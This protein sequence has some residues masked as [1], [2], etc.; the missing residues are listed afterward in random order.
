LKRLIFALATAL[1][2]HA[3]QTFFPQVADGGP[4]SQK[5]T[6]S[7]TFI[8][9]SSSLS[10]PVTVSFFGNDGSPLALDFGQGPVSS[11]VIALPPV[12]AVTIKS[13]GASSTTV[14]G[15]AV[16]QF[17]YTTTIAQAMF[18]FT[19]NGVPQQG[20]TVPMTA[21]SDVFFSP[22]TF[23]TGVAVANPNSFA[24]QVNAVAIDSNGTILASGNVVLFAGQHQAA[25]V[26]QF[27]PN[28]STSFRGTLLAWTPSQDQFLAL[29]I[30][31][32]GGVLSSYPVISAPELGDYYLP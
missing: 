12:G 22:A 18:M 20:V 31:G 26:Y 8:S 5:W 28:L 7:F 9:A 29:A 32:D 14:T 10:D 3:Y 4:A 6:T 23:A 27:F 17:S 11:T 30:S 13:L 1:S 25:D 24:I 21:P 16:A 15:W 19:S 2:A